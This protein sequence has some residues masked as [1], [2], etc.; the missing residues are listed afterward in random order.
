METGQMNIIQMLT[1]VSLLNSAAGSSKTDSPQDG[2]QNGS[3]F[4]GILQVLTPE[5][6]TRTTV[7][8]EAVP[9]TIMP[10]M[11]VA[12]EVAP[13]VVMGV[14]PVTI[15]PQTDVSVVEV[16]PPVEMEVSPETLL[17]IATALSGKAT[18]EV[19]PDEDSG[20]N[21][22][23]KQSEDLEQQ[24]LL[25]SAAGAQIILISQMLDRTPESDPNIDMQVDAVEPAVDNIQPANPDAGSKV[26][27]KETVTAPVMADARQM[28][29]AT[30]QTKETTLR[31]ETPVALTTAEVRSEAAEDQ[32][33]EISPQ[34]AA[35]AS[36]VAPVRSE[37]PA[38]QIS[39]QPADNA[40]KADSAVAK[41]SQQQVMEA[42]S[43]PLVAATDA[44]VAA[45][46][47]PPVEVQVAPQ[48]TAVSDTQ[49]PL[50]VVTPVENK[51]GQNFDSGTAA[52]V[53]VSAIKE[54]VSPLLPVVEA[55][56]EEPQAV[57]VASTVQHAVETGSIMARGV[58]PN[59]GR[60][61]VQEEPL[62][63][64]TTATTDV[65]TAASTGNVLSGAVK[66]TDAA[67]T[68]ED[69]LTGDK[70]TSDQAMS[71]Q[72]HQVLQKQMKIETAAAAATAAGSTP[73]IAEQ[74]VKQVSDQL[75][76]HEIKSGSEQI[77]LRL[78]PENLG[79]LKVN[80]RM[81]NQRLSVEIVTDNRMVRDA[82]MQNSDTLK[83]SLA[84]QNIKMDS[85]NVSSGSSGSGN[86]AGS[87][88]RNQNDWQELARNNQANQWLQGGYSLPK[89][90]IPEK[91]AY[92]QQVEYG[93]L[94]VH[95]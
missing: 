90:F 4:A 91:L 38:E 1:D 46:K 61:V 55:A 93:M 34:P 83:D 2:D 75:A 27:V 86:F 78:S 16:A 28:P 43:R 17:L 69:S 35:A 15:M 64:Q 22:G 44:P 95:Y 25:M 26:V 66:G 47:M 42:Y 45:A 54:P 84:K 33:M 39:L 71:G 37:A 62:K 63:Q 11:D 53:T 58:K 12:V 6:P 50:Q 36:I 14:I 67:A 51:S 72:M 57:V 85:F 13:P 77:V 20:E 31:L 40:S 48:T 68:A 30:Q 18:A 74:V 19:M 5:K 52:V 23:T 3:V 70:S 7:A 94:N 76:K 82:I 73:V 92:N 10:Q 29:A 89:E 21:V 79:E 8:V 81:E 65:K 60:L 32:I 41:V 87:N 59:D 49:V 88:A 80:L 24:E 9:V 56:S